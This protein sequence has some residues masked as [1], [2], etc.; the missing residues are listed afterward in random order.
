MEDQC[1][2]GIFCGFDQNIHVKSQ[3]R[4]ESKVKSD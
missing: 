3:K 4:L 1:V 2:F